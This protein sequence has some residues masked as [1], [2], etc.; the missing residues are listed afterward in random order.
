MAHFPSHRPDSPFIDEGGWEWRSIIADTVDLRDLMSY[1][2]ET[3]GIRWAIL[4]KLQPP[5]RSSEV[6][7]EKMEKSS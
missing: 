6:S 7:E 1:G 3:K 5:K 4:D 2:P